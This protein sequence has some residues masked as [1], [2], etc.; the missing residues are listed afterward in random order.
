MGATDKELALAHHEAGHA[1]AAWWF[2][3]RY[4]KVTFNPEGAEGYIEGVWPHGDLGIGEGYREYADDCMVTFVAGAAEEVRLIG[5]PSPGSIDDE[6]RLTE[7][8]DKLSDD[9]KVREDLKRRARE[10]ATQLVEDHQD[11]IS[12]LADELRR[13]HRTSGRIVEMSRQAISIFLN[14]QFPLIARRR[15]RWRL[16]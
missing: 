12:A 9:P 14:R 13:R 1:V 7:L 4:E 16:D 2:N 8:S 3:L 6:K 5:Q 15:R 10:A 11:E